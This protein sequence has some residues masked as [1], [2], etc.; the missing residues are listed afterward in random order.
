MILS[1][2]ERSNLSSIT[3]ALGHNVSLADYTSYNLPQSITDVNGVSSSLAY[4][5]RGH[6]ISS[7]Q[8]SKDG[9]AIT[10]YSVD[11]LGQITRIQRP[12]SVIMNY[13]YDAARRLIAIS[14]SAGERIDYTLDPMGNITIQTIKGADSHKITL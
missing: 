1:Y 11:A 3:N 8:H 12:N 9:D 13:Q 2:D 10:R 5:A 4:N 6:L 14:N 7:T